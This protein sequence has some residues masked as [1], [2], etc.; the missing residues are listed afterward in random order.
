MSKGM[1]SVNVPKD[2]PLK[3]WFDNDIGGRHYSFNKKDGDRISE[4][5]ALDLIGEWL[6]KQSGQLKESI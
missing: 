1:H 2:F 3:V 4:Y 6:E 5:D